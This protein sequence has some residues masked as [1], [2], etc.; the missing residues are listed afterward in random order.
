MSN[1]LIESEARV[2]VIHPH[3]PPPKAPGYNLRKCSY[4]LLLP[5]TQSNLL[6]KNFI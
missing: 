3:L 2:Y 1:K 5:T 6:H 4:G